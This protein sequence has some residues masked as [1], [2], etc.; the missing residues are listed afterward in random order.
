MIWSRTAAVTDR[1]GTWRLS[2][3]CDGIFGAPVPGETA[4]T[5]LQKDACRRNEKSRGEV[6]ML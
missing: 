6:A 2:P 4:Q 5:L 1:S 3:I